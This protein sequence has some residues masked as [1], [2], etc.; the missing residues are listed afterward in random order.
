M[1]VGVAPGVFVSDHALS[2]AGRT[3]VAAAAGDGETSVEAAD[4]TV[5]AGVLRALD[6]TADV[7]PAAEGALFSGGYFQPPWP[8]QRSPAPPLSGLRQRRAK[9]GGDLDGGGGSGR[10]GRWRPAR[11]DGRVGVGGLWRVGWWQRR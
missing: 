7:L 10:N 2:A 11:H 1:G 5:A 4:G 9:T 8:L 6:V 3:V